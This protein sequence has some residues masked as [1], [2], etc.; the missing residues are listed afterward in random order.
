MYTIYKNAKET[1][2]RLL[3][4]H[5]HADN[6]L[7]IKDVSDKLHTPWGRQE[8]IMR[9]LIFLRMLI[10]LI[11]SVLFVLNTKKSSHISA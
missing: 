6:P 4:S 9:Y 5:F 11:K 2:K 8:E 3:T 10:M 1:C 7:I